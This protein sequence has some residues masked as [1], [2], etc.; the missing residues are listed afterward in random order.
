MHALRTYAHHAGRQVA[1]IDGKILAIIDGTQG[2]FRHLFR[3]L[4]NEGMAE[5][6]T[7]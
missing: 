6:R 2:V 3:S 1:A 4:K 5:H 7:W